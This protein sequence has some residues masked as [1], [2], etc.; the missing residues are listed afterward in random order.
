MGVRRRQLL[1]A[2]AA[3]GVADGFHASWPALVAAV[4]GCSAPVDDPPAPGTDLDALTPPEARVVAEETSA[5]APA[6]TP[7]SASEAWRPF[8]PFRAGSSLG[9]G[10]SLADVTGLV[11][12]SLVVRL[13]HEGDERKAEVRVYRNGGNPRGL[14]HTPELDLMLVTHSKRPTDEDLGRAVW[15]LAG[16]MRGASGHLDLAVFEPREGIFL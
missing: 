7:L 5:A 16:N 3:F 11:E 9:F 12:G 8:A 13:R 6:V 14:A 2:L 10:W 4:G 15:T 1:G